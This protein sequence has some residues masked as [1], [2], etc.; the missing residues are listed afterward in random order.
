MSRTTVVGLLAA[1]LA[2]CGRSATTDVGAVRPSPSSAAVSVSDL[3]FHSSG[4]PPIEGHRCPASHRSEGG[5]RTLIGPTEG[6]AGTSVEIA[7]ATPL[8]AKS[9]RY[10][11]PRGRIGFWFNL[12]FS[13]WARVYSDAG[14][15]RASN[16]VP[17]V[18]L[19]EASVAGFCAYRVTFRV[20]SVPPGRY[21]IVP[22]EHE[23]H[24][25]A[26]FAPLAFRVTG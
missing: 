22:I 17:V 9:G 26:A 10:L 12:P 15:P 21:L 13:A 6:Q 20:P 14:P 3:R 19:G 2:T 18:R 25:A 8:F 1:I 16:G 4:T 24:G 11:G 5:Y 7:G 23:G